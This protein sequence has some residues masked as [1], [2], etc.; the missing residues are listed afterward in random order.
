[1]LRQTTYYPTNIFDSIEIL[2]AV[3]R[4][5]ETRN[6]VVLNRK[7]VVVGDLV[8]AVDDLLGVDDNALLV[9]HCDDLGIARRL[10]V[11]KNLFF[12]K[13]YSVQSSAYILIWV[14][15]NLY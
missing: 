5:T 6:L 10:K 7:L 4:T 8:P 11:I 15:S 14:N 2:S 12:H 13:L 1:M 3:W 9:V